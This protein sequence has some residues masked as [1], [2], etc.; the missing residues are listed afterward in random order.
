MQ[1]ATRESGQ[2]LQWRCRHARCRQRRTTASPGTHGIGHRME[3]RAC[4]RGRRSDDAYC[5]RVDG[6][7]GASRQR[8]K[9]GVFRRF[10]Q[11]MDIASIYLR[12]VCARPVRR[13]PY[14][15]RRSAGRHSHEAS[16][17]KAPDMP[18]PFFIS[19]TPACVRASLAS[20]AASLYRRRSELPAQ[21]DVGIDAVGVRT[22]TLG[23][24]VAV[25][26][27]RIVELI[28]HANRGTQ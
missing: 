18:G 11:S 19:V 7:H 27:E 9:P 24:H 6:V 20:P 25:D 16:N 8:V 13:M 22:T 4:H 5:S 17:E 10:R 14:Q 23:A 1:S 28:T 12:I 26:G 3:L 2:R 21:T 15:S